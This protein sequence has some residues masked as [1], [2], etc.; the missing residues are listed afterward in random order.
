LLAL[1]ADEA[2]GAKYKKRCERH[3]VERRQDR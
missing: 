2:D 1:A 3:C